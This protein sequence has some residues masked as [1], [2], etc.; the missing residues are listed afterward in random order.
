MNKIKCF[1]GLHN[2]EVFQ[3][4]HYTDIS[5]GGRAESTKSAWMC[6]HCKRTKTIIHYDCGHI[7]LEWFKK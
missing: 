7:A 5:Y 1:F 3:L 2:W 6:F 4:E